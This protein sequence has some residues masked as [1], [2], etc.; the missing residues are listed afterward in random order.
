V[1]SAATRIDA[2]RDWLSGHPD[3]GRDEPAVRVAIS[4]MLSELG[5]IASFLR[6]TTTGAVQQ[7]DHVDDLLR[8]VRERLAEAVEKGADPRSG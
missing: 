3:L 7:L 4:M 2:I 6:T 8:H 1:D 5:L